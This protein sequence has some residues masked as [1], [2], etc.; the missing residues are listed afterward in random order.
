MYVAKKILKIDKTM[1]T[2]AKYKALSFAAEDEHQGER[3]PVMA[4]LKR[5]LPIIT[6]LTIVIL[7][8]CFLRL[9]NLPLLVGGLIMKPY[10]LPFIL[11]PITIVAIAIGI[12]YSWLSGDAGKDVDN[13]AA[14]HEEIIENL[15]KTVEKD[16]MTVVKTL[17]DGD[18]IL[19]HQIEHH[20]WVAI[21]N[22]A[23]E[24]APISVGSYLVE[25]EK[26]IPLEDLL[27]M[28]GKILE[29]NP[30]WYDGLVTRGRILGYRPEPIRNLPA[31]ESDLRKAISIKPTSRLHLTLGT[32]LWFQ[33]RNDEAIAEMTKAIELDSKSTDA[34]A[35]LGNVY[36]SSGEKEKALAAYKQAVDIDPNHRAKFMI[37]KFENR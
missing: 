36:V 23:V 24:Q 11:I 19:K 25:K 9:Q 32:V 7:F 21:L 15:Y 26:G 2:F 10:R 4:W 28:L 31:A 14:T 30:N 12:M 33:E 35:G 20:E 6:I 17:F 16:P 22:K 29:K 5:N 1:P 27:P 13:D 34:Y 37:R 18:F 3:N 8:V